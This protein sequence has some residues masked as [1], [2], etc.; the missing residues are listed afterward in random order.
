MKKGLGSACM[1]QLIGMA[2]LVP[3]IHGQLFLTGTNYVQHFDS[4][5]AGMSAGWSVRTNASA[6][7]LGTAVSFS[8]TAKSWG[9]STAE[10]GNYASLT[11]N[12]GAV[13]TGSEL[14]ATQSGFTNRVLGIRQ[15][16]GFGDPGAAFTLQ[17]N[18]TLGISNLVFSADLLLLRSN[19]ASTTWSMEYA[20]GNSPASF[21]ALG[22]FA[23]PGIV[24][25]THASYP[26]G[27]AAN[28]QSQNVWIRIAA[29]SASSGGG[30]RDSFGVDNVQIGFTPSNT[31][32]VNQDPLSRTNAVLSTASFSA[33]AVG[34]PPLHYRWRKGAAPLSD[35]GN[36]SGATTDTLTIGELL[37]ADAGA[38]SLIVSNSFGSVTS[39]L[40]T[41][42]V[43]GFAIEPVPP[44]NTLAG[45]AV[46]VALD[47][48][49]NQ[50]PVNSASGTSGN[51]SILPHANILA[52]AAGNSGSATL[53]PLAGSGGVVMTTVTASDGSFA[54]NI[55]FPLLVVPSTNVIFND[56]F[57]Y[58]GGPVIAASR[59]LWQHESG[60]VGDMVVSGGE[61]QVSRSLSELCYAEL[62]GRPYPTNG[63]GMFYSRFKVR[64]TA[65]P[66]VG[67]NYFA[68]FQDDGGNG[69]RARIWASTTNAAAGKFR[70]GIGN[71]SDS[72]AASA[73][74]AR[75][76]DTNVTYTVV[77]RL[78]AATSESFIWIDPAGEGS[79]NSTTFAA[80]TDAFTTS[81]DITSYAFRQA[82][83]MGIMLVDDLVVGRT[84]A[85]VATTSAPAPIP[86]Y[87]TVAGGK[88]VL[89]WS[90]P[91]GLFKLCTGT[92]LTGI[93]NVV[94]AA[95]P[96]T[97]VI[98]GQRYFRLMY[99]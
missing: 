94:A 20:V 73:Q 37:H 52:A 90:D 92:N 36:I 4:L 30:P 66:T 15:G 10:F 64:F 11:N 26:L 67:G 59:G 97:N 42:T 53:T 40:A 47:F 80:G 98:S 44:T 1:L 48:I 86:L 33:G 77:T 87:L 85:A 56:Y 8:T 29:L 50:T 21:S 18:N 70:L 5:E 78:A 25:V 74:V 17:I 22:T 91:S 68:F 51:P 79:T 69:R 71:G 39:A 96:Y 27:L 49:D 63:G 93:T 81:A 54:T 9:D 2:M 14:S 12:S 38:Y 82:G 55:T 41:L 84:F 34:G 60:T 83:S 99:P 6:S 72:T 58:D 65:L 43:L 35:G 3:E 13:A 16:S 23:D 46:S 75:D 61:L 57:D 32:K 24:G 89:S 88:A 95:G 31:P 19:S 76:L 28:N 45:Q 7:S 62:V